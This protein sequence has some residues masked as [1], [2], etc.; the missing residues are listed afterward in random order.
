MRQAA[1]K[2]A[3][4]QKGKGKGKEGEKGNKGKKD[5][6]QLAP[7]V[8]RW[9]TAPSKVESQALPPFTG[10]SEDRIHLPRSTSELAAARAVLLS[11]PL[12][13]FDTETKPIFRKGVKDDGPH[14]VQLAT[15]SDA[16]LL[17]IH[18]NPDALQLA[19]DVMSNPAILKVGFGL[20][21]DIKTLPRKIGANL[22]NVHDLDHDFQRMGFG[23]TMGVRAAIA[24]VCGK[25]FRKP[26]TVTMSNW[27]LPVYTPQQAAYA[28]NDAYTAALLYELI[29]DWEARQEPRE[30]WEAK[31][32]EEEE[33]KAAEAAAKAEADAAAGIVPTVEN[34]GKA[35][36]EVLAKNSK[37]R[38]AEA[39]RAATQNY[40]G[41]SRFQFIADPRP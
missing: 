27:K 1:K 24:V 28:A 23:K 31:I 39:R 36:L 38:R 19:R 33:R 32:K 34:G 29:P 4:S 7:K 2:S 37:Q 30:Y 35:A 14:L 26:K 10:M 9:R 5:K 18:L 25:D 15:T 16:Y 13:G 6:K 12:L 17:Q 22:A 20:D 8:P 41:E 21:G 40:R 11:A 3:V